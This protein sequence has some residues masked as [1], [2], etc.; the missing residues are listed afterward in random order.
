MDDEFSELISRITSLTGL[1]QREAAQVAFS[2]SEDQTPTS[3]E[4]IDSARDLGFDVEKKHGKTKTT[5]LGSGISMN[6]AEVLTEVYMVCPRVL[7]QHVPVMG[8]APEQALEYFAE[9]IAELPDDVQAMLVKIDVFEGK[10]TFWLR[11]AANDVDR[12]LGPIDLTKYAS[13][14]AL[15]DAINDLCKRLPLV[16]AA[17]FN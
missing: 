8:K 15:T 4:I 13:E 5:A 14:S 12:P 3:A 2:F 1:S 6:P 17:D 10:A 9:E 16:L 7:S 11:D